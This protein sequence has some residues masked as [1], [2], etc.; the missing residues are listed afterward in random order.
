MKFKRNIQPRDFLKI[1]T[2]EAL[3]NC[4]I[5]SNEERYEQARFAQQVRN[6]WFT[7]TSS[8]IDVTGAGAGVNTTNP[9]VGYNPTFSDPII[10]TDLLSMFDFKIN[11][12]LIATTHWNNNT[13]RLLLQIREYGGDYSYGQDFFGLSSINTTGQEF[14]T[15]YE[16]NRSARLGAAVPLDQNMWD[17]LGKHI[18]FVPRLLKPYQRLQV[19]WLLNNFMP[20]LLAG[21]GVQIS[22]QV[23]FR[24]VRVLKP[25][26]P[27]SYFTTSVDRRIR[28][29]IAGSKPETF[30]LDVQFPFANI[31]AAGLDAQAVKTEQNDRPLLILGAICNLQGVQADLYDESKYYQFTN[32]DT[33]INQPGASAPAYKRVPLALWC[34]DSE[35]R[36]PNMFNMFPVPHLLEPGAQLRINITNGLQPTTTGNTFQLTASTPSGQDVRITFLCR[37]V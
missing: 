11:D 4:K 18:D 27:Y 14:I 37:T 21:V 36:N 34:P 1:E 8:P 30:F 6:A 33:R 7:A 23:G 19:Q 12:P 9:I 5:L 15:K 10:I 2:C 3:Q 29:Y 22:P 24:A 13:P 32:V 20:T 31:P 25:D 28:N 17:R 26:N 35:F 16:K